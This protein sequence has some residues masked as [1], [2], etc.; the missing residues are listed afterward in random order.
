MSGVTVVASSRGS[1]S[2]C[3]SAKRPKRSRKSPA[4]LSSTSRRVP[5]RQTWPASSY[6]PAA[7]RAAASRSASA[8]TMN[9]FFPPSSAVKGTMLRAVA[10]PIAWAAPTEPVS[11]TRRTSGWATSAAPTSSPMPWTTFS[12]PGGIPA[13]LARSPS[14]EHDS[15]DHSAGLST[16]VQ[17]AA[18]AGA[19][20]QVESMNGAF[21]GRDDHRG[22]R[23]HPLDA[24]PRPVGAPVALLV[25]QREVR[26]GAEVARAAVDHARAQRAQ[27]HRHV[28]ALDGRELLDVLVDQVGQA[29][30]ERRA[31]GRA[32][33]R[34]GGEGGVRRGDRPLRLLLAAARDLGDH[35]L[36]D[37]RDVLEALAAGDALAADEVVRRDRDALD[38]DAMLRGCRR[39]SSFT[40]SRSSTV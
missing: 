40:V 6:W 31:A 10:C 4:T 24:V 39:H 13:S 34:P 35:L 33:R 30:Q 32:Q 22:A 2:T 23:R 25:G 3:S 26:V 9:G 37:R 5:D 12:T 21:H 20:F 19:V 28:A 1:P 14:S 8:N 38:V 11:A 17:P 36:V 18:S 7:L 16:A 29:V 27:E 15:G